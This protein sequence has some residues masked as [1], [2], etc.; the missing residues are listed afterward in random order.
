MQTCLD[1]FGPRPYTTLRTPIP[2]MT[3]D[4]PND[5]IPRFP[6]T[7]NVNTAKE[8]LTCNNPRNPTTTALRTQ[9]YF[10]PREHSLN[11]P[12]PACA[13]N[14]LPL[15]PPTQRRPQR[16]LQHLR[17]IPLPAVFHRSK[18]LLPAV[19]QHVLFA[20]RQQQPSLRRIP[21]QLTTIIISRGRKLEL[22]LWVRRVRRRRKRR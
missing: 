16:P 21:D 19:H 8:H 3:V 22:A 13:P 6:T 14:V 11:P 5:V 20:L 7:I 9:N 18:Q 2:H 10:S 17:P 4:I 12:T 1:K 15:Q